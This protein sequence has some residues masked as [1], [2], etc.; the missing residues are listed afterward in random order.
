MLSCVPSPIFMQS[1]TAAKDTLSNL[2]FGH[3]FHVFINFFDNRRVDHRQSK[4]HTKK[5]SK[6][7][8]V[9]RYTL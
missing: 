6:F 4:Y 9:R 3:H 2:F 7:S 5:L 8:E 1:L